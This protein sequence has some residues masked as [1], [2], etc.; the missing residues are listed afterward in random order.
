MANARERRR[1]RKGATETAHRQVFTHTTETLHTTKHAVTRIPWE[2]KKEK[3]RR[4][5]LKRDKR[6]WETRL[7]EKER[8]RHASDH[9][10]DEDSDECE[11]GSIG[12]NESE[13]DDEIGLCRRRRDSTERAGVPQTGRRLSG[14]QAPLLLL[15][16]PCHV[17][18][19]P[20]CSSR[21]SPR[22]P[23]APPSWC[24]DFVVHH[25]HRQLRHASASA[26]ARASER[27]RWTTYVSMYV[28]AS[29]TL[30]HVLSRQSV[31]LATNAF[32]R[33][34]TDQASF[35][36][37]CASLSSYL[38]SRSFSFSW[39]FSRVATPPTLSRPFR[40]SSSLRE[41]FL[42]FFFPI[43][44]LFSVRSFISSRF[45]LWRSPCAR[46]R[47]FITFGNRYRVARSSADSR[48]KREKDLFSLKKQLSK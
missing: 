2:K 21:F 23:R 11:S 27:A 30:R 13:K 44:S 6:L 48:R 7:R 37:L 35:G 32:P 10:A 34:Q 4:S 40:I 3:K 9:G 28:C 29:T 17:G 18:L 24:C 8:E 25:Y 15:P 16:P 42:F 45:T 22:P 39:S 26:G 14:M 31:Q 38:S 46:E 41:R 5:M 20:P 1:K 12:R 33:G 36:H 47:C 43:L 19:S